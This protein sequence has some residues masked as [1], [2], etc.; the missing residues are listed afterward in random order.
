MSEVF[1]RLLRGIEERRW[2]ELPELYA[3]DAVV[4]LPFARPTP[5][6]LVGREQLRAHFAAAA[7]LPLEL[8]VRNLVVHRTEHPEIIVAECEYHGRVT[9]TGRTFTTPNI[10]V[11][12]VAHGRILA[13]RD[14]HD[15]ATLAE[16]LGRGGGHA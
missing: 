12:R 14:Y 6:R 5:I 9:T 4:E 2:A 10:F 11:V 7:R 8:A 13:S 3:E 1:E 16:A 15:H